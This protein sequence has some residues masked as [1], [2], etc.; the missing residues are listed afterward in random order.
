EEN[1][2]RIAFVA[3]SV[4]DLI[5]KVGYARLL[6]KEGSDK[7]GAAPPGVYF[8]GATTVREGKLAFILPGLGAAYPN[9][10]AELC[11]HFPDVRAVFDF[12]DELS[13]GSSGQRLPSKRIF[14]APHVSESASSLASMDSAV[15][16]VL[17]AEWALFTLLSYLGINPD[18]FIGC[19][20]GEFAAL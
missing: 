20:T 3:R 8:A 14:P 5:E 4:D 6:I 13:L 9:M 11:L 7:S 15:V 19:S 10:L 1:K 12:V 16:T 18:T 2:E 17:M